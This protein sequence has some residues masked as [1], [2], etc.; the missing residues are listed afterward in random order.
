M[1][2]KIPPNVSLKFAIHFVEIPKFVKV[3]GSGRHLSVSVKC[4][5]S[6]NI[7]I[8]MSK[9]DSMHGFLV[10]KYTL[11][12][13]DD[14]EESKVIRMIFRLSKVP[15]DFKHVQRDDYILEDYP[16]FA[17]PMLEMNDR[18][19]GSVVSICRHL[20]WRYNLSGKTAYDDALVDD[21]AESV[22]E[23]RMQVKNWIDHIEHAPEHACDEVCTRND[24]HLPLTARLFPALERRLQATNTSWLVGHTMTWLDLLVACLVNP[25]IYHR[26]KLMDKFPL[27]YLHNEK[28]AHH[29]DLLGLL[30]RVRQR[31]V[32]FKN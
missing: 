21:I 25:I 4:T 7:P 22:F 11:H 19:Y 15:F 5:S 3:S 10:P 29:D 1:H 18:K 26:P 20:A 14:G 28:I 23:I 30:Y 32:H 12:D 8:K 13:F 31:E 2:E 17:L 27:L 9:L 24:A 6:R 16:Y